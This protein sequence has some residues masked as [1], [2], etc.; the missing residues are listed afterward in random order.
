MLRLHQYF[1]DPELL[2]PVIRFRP[3]SLVDTSKSIFPIVSEG[4]GLEVRPMD[5]L[6]P[7]LVP[8]MNNDNII[9]FTERFRHSVK[10]WLECAESH[11]DIEWHRTFF[12]EE[13]GKPW[14][15]D[16]F[17]DA[18][19]FFHQ[20][21]MAGCPALKSSLQSTVLVYMLGH[22]FYVPEEDLGEVMERT[23]MGKYDGNFRFVSPIH[24]D[25]FLKTLLFQFFR[26][27]VKLAFKHYQDLAS[28]NKHSKLS[29]D[30]I[31]ATSIVLLIVAGSQ[32]SKAVEK[33]VAKHR[34]GQ[35]VDEEAVYT[36]I[37]EIEDWINDMIIENWRYKFS[38]TVKWIDDESRDRHKAYQ[39]KRFDLLGRF[40]K[41]FET[42]GM[43]G[44]EVWHSRLT[45]SQVKNWKPCRLI[46][47]Q[48]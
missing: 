11:E 40:Q 18:C 33:A 42:Y 17:S 1:D 3:R 2:I 6:S 39:A 34:R 47:L 23:G 41:S 29:R 24:I 21:T 37:K 5:I 36:Q 30:R 48:T 35:D 8:A 28:P 45:E 12:R 15:R 19:K 38:K 16:V 10:R 4:K 26:A 22:S 14:P 13:Y 27:T 44:V 31:L 25:R 46:C 9:R 20:V 43:C 32:Q 7:P